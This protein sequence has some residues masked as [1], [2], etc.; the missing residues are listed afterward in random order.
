MADH[1]SVKLLVWCMLLNINLLFNLTLAV[2][3]AIIMS[4]T[5]EL[6]HEFKNMFSAFLG[7]HF[8][9]GLFEQSIKM[10]SAEQEHVLWPM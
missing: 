4:F 5:C 7:S 6:L 3:I 9:L 1:T 8:S 2:T 10:F